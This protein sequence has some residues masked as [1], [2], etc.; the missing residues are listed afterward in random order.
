MAR[1]VGRARGPAPRVA[2]RP[3]M[4]FGHLKIIQ[5]VHQRSQ[6]TSWRVEC[7]APTGPGG[8]PCGKRDTTKQ[9]YLLREKNPKTSCGCATYAGANPYKREKTI[10]QMMN[11][12]CLYPTHAS[13]KYYGALGIRPCPMWI[14]TNPEGWANFIAFMGPAPTDQH[15]LDRINPHLLYGP[16]NCAWATATE[17][18]NNQKRHWAH[19]TPEMIATGRAEQAAYWA[20][21]EEEANAS[22]P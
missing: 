2:I 15:S 20:K 3:G 14:E 7:E 8:A 16:G 6:G 21:L 13:Y 19:W 11:R 17:Q 10:W 9:A 5:K 12:R 18:A 22:K 1:P 4:R